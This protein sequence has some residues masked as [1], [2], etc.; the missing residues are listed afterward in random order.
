M[1]LRPSGD[2]AVVWAGIAHSSGMLYAAVASCAPNVKPKIL[3]F[4]REPEPDMANALR[5]LI[6]QKRIQGARLCGVM[7]RSEYRVLSVELP[8]I[9]QQ[10][11]Q[12]AMRWRLKDAV[13]FPMEDALLDI[14]A[15]PNDTQ[16]RRIQ[17]AMAFV[18]QRTDYARWANLA[19]DAGVRWKALEA[20]ETSLMVLSAAVEKPDQ[21]HALLAF[22]QSCAILVITYKKT[23]LMS[24]VIEVTLD[25]IIGDHETRGA[26]LGRASLEVIRTLDSFERSHSEVSLSGMSVMTPPEAADIVEVLC[27][28]VYVP[29][30]KYTLS[31][32]VDIS[33]VADVIET[34][35]TL[36]E[37]A[38]IG[39]AL[40]GHASEN[41]MHALNLLGET[42]LQ[43]TRV[44]WGAGIGALLTAAVIGV[45]C[46]AGV[47]MTT[48]AGWM[49]YQTEAMTAE[50]SSDGKA[51]VLPQAPAE[52][53]EL[54]ALRQQEADQRE[55]N[56]AMASALQSN[57]R[58]YSDYLIAL[59]RQTLPGL[60]ITGLDLNGQAQEMTLSGRMTEPTRLPSYLARLQNETVFQGRKF[61]QVQLRAVD[62]G[63][64]RPAQLVTF[65]ISEGAPG[66]EP[67]VDTKGG[68][69]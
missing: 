6:R 69:P 33:E 38:V 60:W 65:E 11:W 26:A 37:Y 29:V 36:E 44:S 67:L 10:E 20:P 62:A 23:L 19:D 42:E 17:N 68:T 66:A 1:R 16:L 49:S 47:V 51:K 3:S 43:G 32:W 15:I 31:D 40:R 46:L 21:A 13:D 28:L 54:K 53:N 22:G 56:A 14:V 27:D 61:D 2:Q 34:A 25:A 45:A 18:T 7:D 64:G 8:D 48:M 63:P 52:I 39:A 30:S 57:S 24:R 50:V 5:H 59:A 9:P 35:G 12:D 58:A 55:R 41:E 4:I